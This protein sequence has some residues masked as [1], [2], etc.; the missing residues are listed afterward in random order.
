[1][2]REYKEIMF[3]SMFDELDRL[4][5]NKLYS[6]PELQKVAL[7]L[8]PIISS[9]RRTGRGV[10]SGL[11]NLAQDPRAFGRSLQTSYRK[12]SAG[13][14]GVVGGLKN[15]WRTPAG[16]AAIVGGGAL[17]GAGA[18]L[19]GRKREPQQQVIVQR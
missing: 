7:N 17:L 8:Q 12:G 6:D 13:G 1:M 10:V 14:G 5:A 4:Q 11:R 16:K 9:A 15:V 3:S 18:L 2:D 19:S